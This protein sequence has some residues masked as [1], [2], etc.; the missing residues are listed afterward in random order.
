M[1]L[2]IDP[3]HGGKDPGTSGAGILEKDLNLSL[4]LYMAQRAKELGFAVTLTRDDDTG[5]T[6][7]QRTNI[8]KGS[9][10]KICLSN[11]IN[12]GGGTGTEIIH[13]MHS[14]GKLASMILENIKNTGMATR[15]IYYKE[16]NSQPGQDY[17]FMHRLTYPTVPETLI[18]EYGFINDPL[19]RSKLVN[20]EIQKQL[21][22]AV[23]KAVCSFTGLNYNLP[24]AGNEKPFLAE[25]ID[26]VG[27]IHNVP[28]DAV[29]LENGV[30]WIKAR[31]FTELAGG[32]VSYDKANNKST[33]DFSL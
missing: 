30:T 31:T 4:S 10:A 32:V 14:N 6:P 28:A 21:V 16:S 29:R 5:L 20:P 8:V 26:R 12:A 9:G 23:L 25:I 19:D 24:Q 13:S 22:E 17:Y 33:F 2:C 7:N 15:K 1:K 3:G 18:I 11:H 27:R